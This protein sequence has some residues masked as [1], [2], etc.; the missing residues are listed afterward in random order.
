MI[1]S[2][3]HY[4]KLQCD[5]AVV[6]SQN[7][8][9]IAGVSPVCCQSCY[10]SQQS[11]RILHTHTLAAPPFCH[12]NLGGDNFAFNFWATESNVEHFFFGR[13][14]IFKWRATQHP[15]EWNGRVAR[16]DNSVAVICKIHNFY[17]QRII[18]Y[19]PLFSLT[20]SFNFQS[21]LS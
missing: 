10:C 20:K 16:A 7:R 19:I 14:L 15:H 5:D 17:W 2:W 12:Q 13:P 8:L 1:Q 9:E 11:T 4:V 21:F 18:S 6:A 3:F